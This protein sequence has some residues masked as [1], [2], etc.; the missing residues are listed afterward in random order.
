MRLVAL[1]IVIG[2]CVGPPRGTR[3][4]VAEMGFNERVVALAATYEPGG[5]GGYAWPAVPGTAGTT[6]D[7]RIGEDVIARAGEGNHCVGVTLEVYWRALAACPGGVEHALDRERAERFKREWYVAALGDAGAAGA[8]VDF[9][10]GSEV[11]LDDARP[12]DFVQAWTSDEVQGHSM[13]FLGWERD[14]AGA[15]NGIRYWSSQPWTGGIGASVTAVAE[16]PDAFDPRRIH[17][18]RAACPG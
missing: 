6:R 13:V 3:V 17:I 7:L 14:E 12:G 18:A 2:V 11:A 15:I 10:L 1:A 8:L 9:G 5:F 4:L 16:S